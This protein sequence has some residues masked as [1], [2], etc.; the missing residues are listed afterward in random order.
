MQLACICAALDTVES[1]A[2]SL[3]PVCLFHPNKFGI[4]QI[5]LYQFC[6]FFMEINNKLGPSCMS[7]APFD[8]QQ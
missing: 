6:G 5:D 4:L 7:Y 8:V 1:H 3:R 2:R